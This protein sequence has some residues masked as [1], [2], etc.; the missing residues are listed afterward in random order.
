MADITTINFEGDDSE[1]SHGAR[2]KKALDDALNDIHK[3]SNDV[4]AMEG[5]SGKIYRKFINNLI[6]STPNARYLETG[7]LKGSTACAAMYKNKVG[8]T[9]IDNWHWPEHRPDFFK[10]TSSVMTDDINFNVI[11]KD[12]RAVDYSNIGKFNV[13]MFDGPH[14]EDDQYDGV[15]IAQPALDDTYILIVDDW[16]WMEVQD[17]TW[18]ALRNLEHGLVSKLEIRT[19]DDFTYPKIADHF[20]DWHNGYLIAVIEK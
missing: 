10:N 15:V 8:V 13:Y 11:E 2:I 19:T 1:G 6:A 17:G 9:C 14:S 7:S 16:N 12:F 20:S 18:E 4:M 5:M 3:L